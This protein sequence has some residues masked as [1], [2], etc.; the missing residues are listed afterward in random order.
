MN[1]STAMQM[2]LDHQSCSRSVCVDLVGEDENQAK[3][4]C[5]HYCEPATPAESRWKGK[6]KISRDSHV[7]ACIDRGHTLLWHQQL[8]VIKAS[9]TGTSFLMLHWLLK[10]QRSDMK[11]KCLKYIYI[12][13]FLQQQPTQIWYLHFGFT[14]CCLTRSALVFL[15]M[16]KGY[17]FLLF[18]T[19]QNFDE[20]TSSPKIFSTTSVIQ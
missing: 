2:Q 16:D 11:M 15:F 5:D 7:I 9:L 8:Q 19:W 6:R 12:Y 14:S 3:K 20:N 13:F 17:F 4:A 1:N 10:S 18:H